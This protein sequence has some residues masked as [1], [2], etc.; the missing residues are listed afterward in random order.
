MREGLFLYERLRSLDLNVEAFIANR[1]ALD[2]AP[3]VDVTRLHA[4]LADAATP[5]DLARELARGAE[6]AVER[7]RADAE[8]DRERLTI[9]ERTLAPEGPPLL[10]VPRF[11]RDICDLEGLATYGARLAGV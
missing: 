9:I 10:T 2:Q 5:D 3:Q 4:A 7:A 6:R 8:V 11:E 1:I